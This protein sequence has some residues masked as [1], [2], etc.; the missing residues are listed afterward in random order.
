[1]LCFVF[2]KTHIKHNPAELDRTPLVHGVS[3]L[4]HHH[5]EERNDSRCKHEKGE[6][7]VAAACPAKRAKADISV[8]GTKVPGI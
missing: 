3:H 8:P 2:I 6:T 5:E 1:M 4:E 7:G